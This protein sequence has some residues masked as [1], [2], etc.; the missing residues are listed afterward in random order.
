MLMPSRTERRVKEESHLGNYKTHRKFRDSRHGVQLNNNGLYYKTIII[1]LWLTVNT[2]NYLVFV[3][4]YVCTRAVSDG[5]QLA[6]EGDNRFI[7]AKFIFVL[8][9]K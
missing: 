4:E 6:Q 9:I 2:L 5:R 8:Q 7:V 1:C 3:Y